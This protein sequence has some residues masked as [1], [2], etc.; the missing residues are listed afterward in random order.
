FG[1]GVERLISWICKLKHIRDAIPFP[2]T[3]VRW[4]P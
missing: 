4:R 3:M 1:L 2:R